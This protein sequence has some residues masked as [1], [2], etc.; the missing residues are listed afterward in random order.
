MRKYH[1]KNRQAV[2]TQVYD[3]ITGEVYE[4]ISIGRVML[5]GIFQYAVTYKLVTARRL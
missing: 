2:G 1:T 3:S 4:V 5:N